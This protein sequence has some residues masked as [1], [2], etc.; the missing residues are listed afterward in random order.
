[1]VFFSCD[2]CGESLKKSMV[3]KHCYRCSGCWVLSCLDC[4]VGFEGDAY[5]AHTKCIS[6]AQK[7]QGALYQPGK[8]PANKKK[9]NVGKVT[10][11]A[12]WNAAVAAV[13]A[14]GHSSAAIKTTLQRLEELDNVPRKRKKF[15]NFVGNSFR[16][17]R[18]PDL[19][20][21]WALLEAEFARTKPAATNAPTP[22]ARKKIR[23]RRLCRT[24][25][26]KAPGKELPM[27]A[28]KTKVLAMA[29][30]QGG[31]DLGS[32]KVLR[33]VVGMKARASKFLEVGGGKAAVVR[34]KKKR[35]R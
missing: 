5:K 28:L 3:E 12:R 4:G 21:I 22:A 33:A 18:K 25:V 13:A 17:L 35:K 7:Y 31:A 23:W 11:T 16:H 2:A 24:A 34:M 19:N 9:N 30:E 15:D 27:A 6:E 8:D 29:K 14:N 10:P 26:W 20:T 32:D 1:M